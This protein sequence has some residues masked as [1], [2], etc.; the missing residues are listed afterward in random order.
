ML[1]S[2]LNETHQKIKNIDFRYEYPIDPN[3]HMLKFSDI[4]WPTAKDS[5]FFNIIKDLILRGPMSLSSLVNIHTDSDHPYNSV[6]QIFYRL[7]NGSSAGNIMSFQKM[8]IISKTDR[9]YKLTPFGVLYAI[10][11]F[12]M[13]EYYD[14]EHNRYSKTQDFSYQKNINGILDILKK[15]YDYFPL[16][17][18]NLDYV[19]SHKDLDINLIF[20]MLSP[21]SIYVNQSLYMFHKF[22]VINFSDELEKIIPFI[23]YYSS[24]SKQIVHTKKPFK[25]KDKIKFDLSKISDNLLAKMREDLNLYDGLISNFL[26]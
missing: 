1:K 2:I 12:H 17:F 21:N 7:L 6:M 11:V 8:E 25:I 19:K 18:D 4:D 20:D 14:S 26:D 23:F 13:D 24:I 15:H 22:D 16:L 9:L 3:F 5:N 10:K